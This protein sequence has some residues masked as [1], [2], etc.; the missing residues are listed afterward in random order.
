MDTTS[1]GGN[2][3]DNGNVRVDG[4]T[5]SN[6]SLVFAVAYDVLPTAPLTPSASVLGTTITFTWTAPA[7]NGGKTVSG[8][9]IQRS[10]DNVVFT[11]LVANTGTTSTTYTDPN[12]PT[13]FT[14]SLK[15]TA[16]SSGIAAL[17]T[18]IETVNAIQFAGQTV[19]LSMWLAT[20][21]SGSVN[22]ELDYST[23]T[24]VAP[25]GTWTTIGNPAVSTTSTITR[26]SQTFA[27]PSTAKSLRIYIGSPTLPTNG[28]INVTGVQLELGSVATAFQRAGGTIQGELAACQRYFQTY[29]DLDIFGTFYGASQARFVQY[30]PVTMRTAPTPTFPTGTFTNFVDQVGVGTRTPTSFASNSMKP[31]TVSWDA[32]G[33]SGATA[34]YQAQ[35]RGTNILFSAEL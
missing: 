5:L 18:A 26:Y 12:L 27:V 33:M 20:S 3:T 11:T 23:S 35:Y 7:D 25:G 30:F 29:G 24:D 15:A 1:A 28:T 34:G 17:A 19:T 4:I 8:Y 13:G 16:P 31:T 2:F 21:N 10:T 14:Y 6:G 9:R 22:I 32:L